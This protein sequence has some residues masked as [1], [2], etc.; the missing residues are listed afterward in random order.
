MPRDLRA[1]VCF[2]LLLFV[3][4]RAGEAPA[5]AVAGDAARG[6]VALQQRGCANCH[7]GPGFVAEPAPRLEGVG[8]RLTPSA[9]RALLGAGPRMPECVEALPEREREA[10]RTA[11]THFLASLGGPLAPEPL[12]L[13]ALSVE[14]GRQLYHTLGCV[15]CHAAFESAGTL[16]RPLWEYED[17][18]VPAPIAAHASATVTRNPLALGELRTRTTQ[19]ALAAYLVDPLKVNPSGRMPAMAIG[20]GEA[21]DLAAYLFYEDA[22][23][24]GAVLAPGP[25]LLLD[26]Y[27]ASFEGET[28]DFDALVPVR[29]EMA[30]SFFDGLQ[31]RE[32]D[33]GFR[34][35][36]LLQ[37]ATAGAYR[38]STTSDDGSMLSLD[39]KLVVD[40][41]G[42]HG[43]EEQ[44][45]E[46][47]LEPGR[48]AFELTYF[49]HFGGDGLEVEWSGPGFAKRALGF[50]AL[51]HL[52]VRHPASAAAPFVL[53]SAKVEHG[54][55]LY[56]TL[57]CANCH[58]RC[59]EKAA[60]LAEL[61][62]ARGC[63]A[64]KAKGAAPRYRF[65]PGEREDLAAA[66]RAGTPPPRSASERLHAELTR[67]NCVA[68]HARDGVGGPD[69]EHRPFFAVANGLD[70]GD[71]GRLPPRLDRVGA[72]L[73]PVWLT[74][75]LS[76][77]GRARPYMKTRM[78]QFG[79]DVV[80]ALPALFAEADAA[81]RDEREPEF[82]MA[83]VEAGKT[84]VGT[85]ALGCIQCHEFA[86]HPSL[87]IPAVDLAKVHERIYPG[88]FRELLM[89]PIAINMN[90]RM[91][92]FWQNGKSPVAL[93]DHD[94]LQQVD[95]LWT[96]LSLGQSMPLPEGLVPVEGEF[97]VEVY[98]TPVVVG[99]F[100]EGVSPRTL[101]VGLPERVHYAFD[102]QNSRL[103]KAWR[104]RFFN[105]RGTWY[106]RAGQL[107]KPAGE[108]VLEFPPGPALA[109]LDAP[110]DPWLTEIG[111]AAGIRDLG[112][113]FDEARRPVFAYSACGIHVEETIVPV[114]KA[115]GSGLVR[116]FKT[117]KEGELL[118]L[119][120]ALGSSIAKGANGL[121]T[122]AG[123][124]ELRVRAPANAFVVNGADGAELRVPVAPAE[125]RVEVEYSW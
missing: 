65:A 39:G 82:S 46:L 40:N 108:D 32:D 85:K 15:A 8:A 13:D 68:C 16:A 101:A 45:V 81:L 70:L 86:G 75:V 52:E 53:D 96:Y 24:E 100:M 125:H 12:A 4:C 73:R 18:Y 120:A 121:W 41:R 63:L 58:T 27:E 90:T 38:F 95:A 110:G 36:G 35:R 107:E 5:I 111:H 71:E 50:D 78:P 33:F 99:V 109:M 29:S 34:F 44:S 122:I 72:K 97:D 94:P 25:G 123:E 3:G 118:F 116:Q 66:L 102:V 80:A 114:L 113:R 57:G 17:A 87:G 60:A 104:G 42:Q 9:L 20:A 23:D 89:D 112:R 47:H 56:E 7:A 2:A 98:D 26:C 19:S 83:A 106:A 76:A 21:R 61:D 69:D 28:A 22:A 37:I 54:R 48:H 67:L 10:A 31:H 77:G 1:A 14:R 105:A 103:A 115:G 124:R 43:M 64:P 117:N 11:L 6:F 49:E 62:P 51:S 74:A 30:T 93:F 79:A 55:E 84:L 119:R 59:G 91:P 88:W 92:T